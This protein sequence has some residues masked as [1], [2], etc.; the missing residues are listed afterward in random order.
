MLALQSTDGA[1]AAVAAVEDFRKSIQRPSGLKLPT[2]TESRIKR[3]GV[4]RA[5]GIGGRSMMSKIER[6]GGA[7]RSAE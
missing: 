4:P 2:S 7:G 3:G 1:S 6:M 5:S